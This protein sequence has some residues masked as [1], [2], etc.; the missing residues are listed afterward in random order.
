MF[1]GL[2]WGYVIGL[3][4]QDLLLLIFIARLSWADEAQK[5]VDYTYLLGSDYC[6]ICV[7]T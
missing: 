6:C 3:A 7:V 4:T 5:V 2:W 1:V